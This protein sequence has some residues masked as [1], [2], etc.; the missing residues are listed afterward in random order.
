EA[1][2]S[3]RRG[4]AS[5]AAPTAPRPAVSTTPTAL[6][7]RS[8]AAPPHRGPAAPRYRRPVRQSASPV[9]PTPGL[10]NERNIMR[11][12]VYQGP[13]EVAGHAVRAPAVQAPAAVLVRITTSA[14]RGS[15]LHMA[16]GRTDAEPGIT[17][18]HDTM[19]VI[20]EVGPGVT[21]LSKG[22]RVVVPFNVACGF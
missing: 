17:F 11:A 22:D 21:S 3:W 4:P 19:G 9:H 8:I 20:E 1:L 13:Y 2:P 16:E 10:F 14:I 15:D 7:P 5:P 6:R 18:G 12:L